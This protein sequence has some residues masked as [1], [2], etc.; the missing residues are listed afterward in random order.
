MDDAA[1][2]VSITDLLKAY[3]ARHLYTKHDLYQIPLASQALEEAFG[4]QII[5]K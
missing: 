5:C 2:V 1:P 4:G 3:R